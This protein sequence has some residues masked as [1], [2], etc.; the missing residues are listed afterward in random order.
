LNPG[1]GIGGTTMEQRGDVGFL[2]AYNND[3][4]QRTPLT[5]AHSADDGASWQHITNLET[6]A[7]QF[8]YP[9]VVQDRFNPNEAHVCYTYKPT[10]GVHTM[11]IAKV[12]FK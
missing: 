2:L 11:A 12:T 4:T 8:S 5:L 1:S 9:F 6:A 3:T 10:G 7:G